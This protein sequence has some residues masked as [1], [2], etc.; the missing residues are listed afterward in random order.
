MV[1]AP[2]A[3]ADRLWK[4]QTTKRR[5]FRKTD[6][7]A[8]KPPAGSTAS[9]L[10]WW[11]VVL[12]LSAQHSL[13]YATTDI[14]IPGLL[15][16]IEPARVSCDAAYYLPCARTNAQWL[17][18][19]TANDIHRRLA[20]AATAAITTAATTTTTTGSNATTISMNL[21]DPVSI[22][23]NEAFESI[24]N[25]SRNVDL[26][27]YPFVFDKYTGINM[28]HG[29]APALVGYDLET[30][31]D[32][33]GIGFS[34]VDALEERFVQA[35]ESPKG[36]DWVGY[37]WSDKIVQD[38]NATTEIIP[39]S[40]MAY[41]V[42]LADR[43]Y[44]GVGYE[45][46]QLPPDEPCTADYDS[47][48]SIT[49]VR[50]LIGKAQ[51]L[52]NEAESLVQFENGLF[53]LSF[54]QNEYRIRGGFYTFVYGYDAILRSHALIHEELGNSF[55]QIMLER[56]LSTAEEA[57]QLHR[58]FILA[59]EGENGGWIQY[60][61][62]PKVGEPD[63]LKIAFI[64]KIEFNDEEYYLGAGF[65]F[66]NRFSNADVDRSPETCSDQHNLPCAF[67]TSLQLSSHA[68]T[69]AISSPTPLNEIWEAISNDPTFRSGGFYLYA[70][71]FNSTCV[72]HGAVPDYAGMT[73][74]DVFDQND[75]PIDAD[76]LHNQFR[77]AAEAGGGWV[78]YDWLIPGVANSEF[79]K[80]AYLFKIALEGKNYYGGIGFN[81]QRG[82]VEYFADAGTKMNGNPVECSYL[83]EM[84]CSDKNVRAIL[85]QAMG[86]LTLASS[87][88]RIS[89]FSPM[90]LLQPKVEDVLRAITNRNAAFLVNDFFVSF[91]SVDASEVC[92]FDDGSG[93]C[94]AHGRDPTLV[95]KTWQQILDSE[96]I[97]SIQGRAL[98]EQLTR[99]SNA[100]AGFMNYPYSKETGVTRTK[101]ARVSSYKHEG[102]N[103]Y[104]VAEY[105]K[106]PQPPTCDRCPM[107]ME[108]ARPTQSYCKKKPNNVELPSVVPWV[109][110][111]A[112]LM[113]ISLAAF[114]WNKRRNWKKRKRLSMKIKKMED[115][116]KNMVQIV[117]EIPLP[118][119]SAAEYKAR[120]G[121]EGLEAKSSHYFSID[122]G[123]E[124]DK[125]LVGMH[126]PAELMTGTNFVKYSSFLSNEIE[127]AYVLWK[128]GEGAPL[129]R[130]DLTYRIEKMQNQEGGYCYVVDFQNMRQTNRSSGHSRAVR[131]E[132]LYVEIDPKV[133]E[134]LPPLPAGVDFFCQ[135]GE[136]FLPT[137]EGQVIQV[138]KEHPNKLW[139]Y[140]SILHD[141]L[142]VDTHKNSLGRSASLIQLSK[143]LH[144]SPSSGWFPSVLSKPADPEVMQKIVDSVGEGVGS[145]NKPDSWEPRKE[146]RIAVEENA[147]EYEKV[148]RFFLDTLQHHRQHVSITKVERIQSFPLWQ[149]YAVKKETM[150]KRDMQ[151]PENLMHN[152][153]P[154]GLE[155]RWLFHGTTTA[156]IPKIIKQGFNR[157]FAGRNA[158]AFGKGVYFAR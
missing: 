97:S 122:W 120:F 96:D 129:F 23:L 144:D 28:A 15:E 142:V 145:L 80:I 100:Y 4:F 21:T 117:E 44:L 143:S 83:Y 59:A 13:T 50:S 73:L 57:A 112:G 16:E 31:F 34:Q 1:S 151:H 58:D 49:N 148:A 79:T 121:Q 137:V 135:D 33:I 116:F 138:S 54:N 93:C 48:C 26:G 52:L 53:E 70:Y 92:E 27:F 11:S 78:L 139:M 152:K 106:T 98:H 104:A 105:F 90:G 99:Q 89:R 86:D 110:A 5:L 131:R 61:W 81:H 113:L 149:S 46:K 91:F 65:N 72:A 62:R 133:M 128:S 43:Y 45:K 19:T 94:L 107:D 38:D 69:H 111:I 42:T 85:G 56:N 136:D 84:G 157:A 158:V 150:K 17:T 37:L 29:G 125:A 108:C 55:S 77:T 25:Q 47:W 68:L 2:S 18:V 12:L 109:I 7:A 20:A 35:S 60:K 32:Q 63:F 95:G 24:N 30:I 114:Y 102:K 101:H 130:L 10:S 88:A 154:D 82:P 71:D 134:R 127:Q 67:D 41:V 124:E 3:D 22:V 156:A 14:I 118:C 66:A 8:N 146:G 36:G 40:K 51:G 140:G 132:Q 153:D 9:S 39:H 74:A 76:I 115:Q 147:I 123:W 126:K 141:P 75:I 119:I 87:E 103:Y 64:V 6:R 155:R